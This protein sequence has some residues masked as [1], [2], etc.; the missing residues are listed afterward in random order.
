MI[1]VC[2]P[3]G[4]GGHFLGFVIRALLDQKLTTTT[5]Q[6]NFH[7][8]CQFDQSFL[9][10]SLLD[11]QQHSHEEEL[12]NINQ[13]NSWS[14]LVIGHFRNVDAVY[15]IHC[16]KTVVITIDVDNHELL[17][18]RVLKEAIDSMFDG[19]KYQDVRGED[20][21]LTNPGFNN[22]PKWIQLEIESQLYK[23]FYFWN[24]QMQYNDTTSCV[25]STSDIFYGNIVEKLANYLQVPVVDG[26]EQLHKNYQ[27]L[28]YQKYQLN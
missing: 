21:P 24:S 12:C 20:W 19:I 4:S 7:Q 22:L 11:N 8:L 25:L 2:F 9:N 28:V 15:K 5:G 26:L 10:F 17:V 6:S 16:C 14:K 1:V 3:G 13:I 23:M 27:Q 18:R